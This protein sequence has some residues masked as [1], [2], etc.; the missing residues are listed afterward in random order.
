M[1][2]ANCESRIEYNRRAQFAIRN[3]LP[4]AVLCYCLFFFRLED[5]DLWNSHEARAGM[6][7]QT[8][9][10]DGGLPRLFDGRVE[11]QKPPLYYWLVAEIAWLRGGAVDAWAVRLPAALS[12]VGCVA[13][14]ALL[15]WRSGRWYAG[16]LAGLVLATAV[17]FTWL[18]RV[19][20]IDIPLTLTVTVAVA[21]MYLARAS[22]V[23]SQLNCFVLLVVAYLSTA[24]GV[25]LKGPIGAVL[26]VAIIGMHLLVEG[27]LP[28]PWKPRAW[29]RLLHDLGL[30]WGIPLVLALTLPWFLWANVATDGEFCRVF[31]WY[32]NVERGFGGD[33][34]RAHEWWFY[35]PRFAI[36]FLPWT[37]LLEVAVV[38]FFRWR[39]WRIDPEARFGLVWL[40]TV[41]V[42][43]SCARY[44]RADYI[45]PAY[46]GAALFLGCTLSSWV[47]RRWQTACRWGALATAGIAAV[48]WAV[49]V[50]TVLPAEESTREYRR[51]A[52]EV[53]ARAPA[54]EPIVFFRTEAHALAFH[55]G[56]P[57][58]VLVGWKELNEQLARPGT[59]YIVMPDDAAA[60]W[61]QHLEGVFLEEV[62]RNTDLAGGRHE[63]PLVLLR[64]RAVEETRTAKVE[65]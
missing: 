18:A 63:K 47:P 22:H 15:G 64:G 54:P 9:L 13:A 53:R 43:L 10:E 24:A 16:M 27:E 41:L 12:A 20:R 1:Q 57:L 50:T 2:I 44:K 56:R 39:L 62:L 30:W 26:P 31:F 4:L 6:D 51:F 7:A 25:M 23:V 38:W 52:A 36:D 33:H 11:L 49:Y 60:E 65:Q 59:R 61:R 28:P 14:V 46:P 48:V 17:H 5:R 40:A 58:S 34:L 42:L 45:L 32:H 19:G 29:W 8:V 37:P 35:G 21:A 55:V 3:V